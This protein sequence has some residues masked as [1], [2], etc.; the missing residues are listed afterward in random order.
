MQASVDMWVIKSKTLLEDQLDDEGTV[1]YDQG[2]DVT[3]VLNGT[4]LFLWKACDNRRIGD[5]VVDLVRACNM[6][7]GSRQELE[8]VQQDCLR[9]FTALGQKGIVVL[10]EQEPSCPDR[11]Q[12]KSD[13]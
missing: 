1:L 13:G 6:E 10:A 8:G 12:E 4:G 3:H 11:A 2:T 9:F 7:G 5:V